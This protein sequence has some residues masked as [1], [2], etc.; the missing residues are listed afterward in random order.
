MAIRQGIAGWGGGGGTPALGRQHLSPAAVC[1]VTPG[2]PMRMSE[3][4]FGASSG[5]NFENIREGS[6][7]R[8]GGN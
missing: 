1:W 6:Q 2:K 7:S 3:R 4:L 8:Y 5:I